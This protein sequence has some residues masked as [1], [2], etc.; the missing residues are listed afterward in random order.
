MTVTL[1]NSAWV[2][3]LK[4]A[5][6]PPPITGDQKVLALDGSSVEAESEPVNM[7]A[8]A[9]PTIFALPVPEV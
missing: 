6:S 9:A 8:M 1:T 5:Y 3:S 2:S 4:T 7:S